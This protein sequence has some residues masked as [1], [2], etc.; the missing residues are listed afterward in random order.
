MTS[1]GPHRV[2]VVTASWT[3]FAICWLALVDA[4][5]PGF[6]FA[7]GISG[8]AVALELATPSHLRPAWYRRARRV[9]YVQLAL[10][11]VYV[12]LRLYDLY[13]GF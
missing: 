6:V 3:L 10:F 2:V 11:G 7:M 8:F 1:R 9:L 4:L 12:P 5:T 13:F